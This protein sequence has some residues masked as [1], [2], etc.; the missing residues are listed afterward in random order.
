MFVLDEQLLQNN[1]ELIADVQSRAG[2]SVILAF[3]GF[4]MWGAFDLVR[5]YLKG[6]AASSVSEARLAFEE[7]KC[8]A[9][10]YS[11]AYAD[12]E[13]DQIMRYSGH[14]TFNSLSQ[15]ERFYGRVQSAGHKISCGLRVNPEYSPVST[16][17]YN[18]CANGSRLGIAAEELGE[19][20][21]EGI[22]GLHFHAL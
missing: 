2:V 15:F 11:P 17:L 18:P 8:L 16:D 12:W 9:H 7:M 19:A 1:L 21:P 14:I 22:E 6:A 20:L 10:T 3:K 4:A 13:F 5:T